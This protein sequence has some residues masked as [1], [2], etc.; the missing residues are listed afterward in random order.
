MKDI[1]LLGLG[2]EI[3]G[4]DA[5]GIIALREL[6]KTYEDRIDCIESAES[7]LRLL[8]YLTGYRKVL[9]LDSIIKEKEAPGVIEEIDIINYEESY[10]PKSPHYIGLP[11][12]LKIA[13]NLNMDLPDSLKVLALNVEDPYTLNQD[14]TPAVKNALPYYVAFASAIID[15]WLSANKSS[16]DDSE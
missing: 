8:D 14:L 10:S 11:Y 4:D 1:L 2:N 3:L 16:T 13:K 12:T 9:I 7:G 6:Q 15:N 5:V